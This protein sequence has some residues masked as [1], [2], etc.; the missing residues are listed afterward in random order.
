MDL[1]QIIADTASEYAELTQ[2][3][4]TK[5]IRAK[6]LASKVKKLQRE[7]ERVDKVI[8]EFSQES[9]KP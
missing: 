3:I 8:K 9:V 7:K 4:E 6:F 5:K 2:E 1:K